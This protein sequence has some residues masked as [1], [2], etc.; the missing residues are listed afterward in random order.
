MLYKPHYFPIIYIVKTW[1]SGE[2]VRMLLG[3]FSSFWSLFQ[4]VCYIYQSCT[5]QIY[6]E[7]LKDEEDSCLDATLPNTDH[8]FAHLLERQ[9]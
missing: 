9:S 8:S 6:L 5:A 1:I 4:Y 2:G 3:E 7:V